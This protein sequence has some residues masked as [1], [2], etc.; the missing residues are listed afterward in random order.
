M[1]S[2][3][4]AELFVKMGVEE[5]VAV[6]ALRAA[7]N[8]VEDMMDYIRLGGVLP[9]FDFCPHDPEREQAYMN[10]FFEGKKPL[11][12]RIKEEK[13]MKLWLAHMMEVRPLL[14]EILLRNK[15]YLDKLIA[16]TNSLDSLD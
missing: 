2:K 4:V 7:E 14:F 5:S 1:Y 9:D 16:R 10:S 6:H 12:Q 13:E 15:P 11:L 3:R 8:K